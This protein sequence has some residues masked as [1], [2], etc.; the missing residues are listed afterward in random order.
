MRANSARALLGAL[1]LAAALSPVGAAW[2]QV[3]PGPSPTMEARIAAEQHADILRRFGG[4]YRDPEL[5]AYV[6]RVGQALVRVHGDGGYRF[7]F[8]VIDAADVFAFTQAG[9]YVYVSRGMIALAN[10]EDELAAVLA[11]ELVHVFSRHGAQREAMRREL[12]NLDLA[13][14]DILYA[15]TRDQELEADALSIP[16]LIAAGYDPFAQGRFLNLVRWHDEVSIT[17]G[18]RRVRDESD[19]THPALIERAEL[20]TSMARELFVDMVPPSGPAGGFP[21]PG[22]LESG[23]DD[24]DPARIGDGSLMSVLDGIVFGPR[25]EAGYVNGNAYYDARRRIAFE[26]P[27]GFHFTYAGRTITAEGPSGATMRFDSYTHR[28]TFNTDLVDYLGR[29]AGFRVQKETAQRLEINRP[30]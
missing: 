9:G 25:P 29:V 28:R 5:T 19:I 22:Y 3:R 18:T 27:P 8:T 10:S 16:I 7:N 20:A 12:G 21:G 26:L 11:H 30:G 23:G 17:N 14:A 1:F 6:E 2:A 15:F 24:Y 4:E 13:D